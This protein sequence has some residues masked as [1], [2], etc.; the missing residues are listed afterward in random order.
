[1]SQHMVCIADADV[2]VQIACEHGSCMRY[3]CTCGCVSEHCFCHLLT[4]SEMSEVHD[5]H[6]YTWCLLAHV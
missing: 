4:L 2:C 3:R 1:M 6:V 5:A